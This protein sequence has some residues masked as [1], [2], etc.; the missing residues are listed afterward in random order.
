M[1]RLKSATKRTA[2]LRAAVREV[3]QS[4]LG[5]PTAKI[6]QR[7]GVAAGTLFTYFATKQQLLN[8]LYLALKS[9]VY[10]R[11]DAQFPGKGSLERRAQHIWSS[12]LDWAIQ[13]PEKRKVSAQLNLSDVITPETRE[14]TAAAGSAVRQTMRELDRRTTPRGLPAG[15]AA[16]AMMALQEATMEFVARQPGRRK[17]LMA[18]GFQV[19]WRALRGKS[20]TR[21]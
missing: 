15:F 12:Y 4:G 10:A 1:A 19:F 21:K 16:A 9:E 7:A 13:F 17:Q 20:R 11:V 2:I 8:E 6:A 14:K 18:R 3:A 5:A